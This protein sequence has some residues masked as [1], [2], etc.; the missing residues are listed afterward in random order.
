MN[1]PLNRTVLHDRHEGHG[2]KMVDFAGWRMPVQYRTGIIAEHLATRRG[3]GLFDVSHM[4]RYRVRGPR[5]ESFLLKTLTNNATGLAPLEAQYTFIANEAG[6]AVDDAYLY[7]LA[8]RDYL[9]VVNA[10]NRAADWERLGRYLPGSGVELADESDALAMLSLQGPAASDV[11]SRIVAPSELPENKRN[12]LSVAGFEGGRLI[13]ART[14]YTGESV[15][16]ELFPESGAAVALWERLVEAG[17][18]PVGLGARD[19]LRLEAGLP[20][21]GHEL[22]PGPDGR[23]IPLFANQIARFAVR[24]GPG[25]AAGEDFVGGPVLRAQ[26]AEYERIRRRE[27]AI[28]PCDRR[29]THLVQPV[30]VFD[31]RRPLRQGYKVTYRGEDAGWITSGTTVPYAVFEGEGLAAKPGDAHAMRPIGLAL[32][33]SD[34][35]PRSHEALHV[36]VLDGRGNAMTAEVVERNAWPLS[37]FVRP[38][39]GFEAPAECGPVPAR[40]PVSARGRTPAAEAE[41]R[42]A[43]LA[44]E[45]ERNHRWRRTKCVNLIPSENCVSE[46]VERLCASDPAGRY[47]EHNRLRALG[48]NSDEV[49]YYKGTGFSMEK[50]EELVAALR[51]FFGCRD[52]E[53]RV[54]SGQMANDTVYDAL[55]QFRNRHRGRRTPLPLRR[56]LVHDLNKG[57]HLSAQTGGALRNYVAHDPRTERPAVDHFALRRDLPHAIDVEETAARILE[58]RPDLIVFGRSV[59]IHTEPVREIV[60]RVHRGFGADNPERP[61]VMYDAAHVLGLL[62]G[63]FQD[64]LAEGADVVTGSTHK[65]FFGPQRG[66]IL[67]NITPGHVFEEF[68]QAVASRA[69]P[70]HVSN[71]H[72]G[73]LLGLL[74]AT[75]EMIRYRDEYPPQVIRNARAFARALAGHGLAIEGDPAAGYTDTHQVLVRGARGAGGEMADR[76]ERSNV[77]T[78]PQAFY[79]DASFAA[80]SGIRLGT[81]EM[82]RF[83]MEE[84]DF[85]ALAGLVAAI[86]LETAAPGARREDVIRFRRRFTRMRYRLQPA[87]LTSARSEACAQP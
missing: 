30:A 47:N 76:L 21:Y 82:T 29:L 39:R 60:E 12:R 1:E 73:T 83:G 72:L 10:G 3:A 64:P 8:D 35:L 62:G 9:L 36:E 38:F 84:A 86:L 34:L 53:V 79:D 68:W 46:F 19:S 80:A 61:L 85:E 13:I 59:I 57:G 54:I 43:R 74:G 7:K 20:L 70:G 51:T 48:V 5:A 65:T 75:C 52:A 14:G 45:A 22:G 44:L 18:T 32:L 11:L 26:R 40:G 49:R 25:A 23:D 24:T 31:G 63:H 81:Q 27:I 77:I 50:E 6:G 87:F 15:C 56:V 33:R 4:G 37:P 78:N 16:F 42:A 69:F 17:A 28:P 58:G 71:H 67:T 66:V 41:S 55:K 2:G